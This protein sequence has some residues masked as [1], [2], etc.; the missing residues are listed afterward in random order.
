MDSP[1]IRVFPSLGQKAGFD[2]EL[3]QY[4]Y[5]T[6]DIIHGVGYGITFLIGIS[7]SYQHGES[8]SN[9]RRNQIFR[10]FCSTLFSIPDIR[11]FIHFEYSQHE[12]HSFLV[13]LSFVSAVWYTNLTKTI[14]SSSINVDNV[15]S[16]IKPYYPT[17]MDM[18]I[19]ITMVFTM[20]CQEHE[21]L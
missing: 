15:S 2:V 8:L 1:K 6:Y 12:V 13:P 4:T 5:K 19:S 7:I 17:L 16:D 20:E 3:E 18:D 14:F 21:R 10:I 11:T 9:M